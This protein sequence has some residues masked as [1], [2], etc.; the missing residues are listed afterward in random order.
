MIFLADGKVLFDE[1]E[2]L[3]LLMVLMGDG[4]FLLKP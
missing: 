2:L 3:L 4:D 1:F